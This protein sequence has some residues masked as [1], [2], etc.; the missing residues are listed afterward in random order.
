[1]RLSSD[2]A[3]DMFL[4]AAP[5]DRVCRE[6][7]LIPLADRLARMYELDTQRMREAMRDG[8]RALLEMACAG[9][10]WVRA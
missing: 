9:V 6:R 7:P 8:D 10:G 5:V 1:M 3:L 2:L 4:K